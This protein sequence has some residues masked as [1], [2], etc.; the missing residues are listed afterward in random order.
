MST[1][2]VQQ[3]T[4]PLS[5]ANFLNAPSTA[6]FLKE[7]LAEKKSEFVSNLIALCDADPKLAQC[8]PAQ[9]MKCAM[10]ATSLNLPLNKNLGY[11]YVIAYKGVPSFQIGYKG[12]IQLAIRTGQY[13][14]INATEI[15]EGEIRHNKITGEVIFNGEKPDAPIVGYMSY[16]ELVNGFT[17]S[18]YMTEE[19]IEQHALRFSQTYKNDKQYRSSTSK[20]SDPLARPTMCKKTVLKLLLGTYGLMTTEF[21][22]ALDSDSDD[23]VSTSGHRFEEAEIVQQGEPNEEQSDEPKRMEI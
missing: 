17:A 13:K 3:Q 2:Q 14:F 5:L 22:K 9:L 16:L 6:N 12:L 19:Q 15:R 20:W 10:N 23:E 18:L 4:K 8:D 11:A 1:Q 21:A 7:T